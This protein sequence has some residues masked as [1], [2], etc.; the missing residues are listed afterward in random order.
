MIDYQVLLLASI[1]MNFVLMVII[2]L[3]LT[4]NFRRSLSVRAETIK[5]EKAEILHAIESESVLNRLATKHILLTAGARTSRAYIKR[6]LSS[7]CSLSKVRLEYFVAPDWTGS[8]WRYEQCRAEMKDTGIN[9]M[10]ARDEA[11][12]LIFNLTNSEYIKQSP[13]KTIVIIE[14]VDIF[15][16][17]NKHAAKTLVD[18]LKSQI[19]KRDVLF[20]LTVDEQ[21]SLE[22]NPEIYSML[23]MVEL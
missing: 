9:V 2:V 21:A 20:I 5:R 8:N 22:K 1:L 10:T 14:N 4:K 18:C 3:I 16:A 12:R 23:N 17:M 6:K 7:I 15:L 19:G 11:E 13:T